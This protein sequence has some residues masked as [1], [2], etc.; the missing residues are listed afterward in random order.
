MDKLK[1]TVSSARNRVAERTSR[2]TGTGSL[3]VPH[4]TL[5]PADNSSLIGVNE[6]NIGPQPGTVARDFANS[7]NQPTPQPM[8][9]PPTSL[10]SSVDAGMPVPV[11]ER[12]LTAPN[13]R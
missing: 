12:P 3:S 2:G 11:P 5:P 9:E 1:T 10:Q 4:S 7:A 6:G 8:L 13:A